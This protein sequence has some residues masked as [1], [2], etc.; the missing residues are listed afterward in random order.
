M[1]RDVC[2]MCNG[3]GEYSVHSGGPQGEEFVP[4]DQCDGKG[5][6]VAACDVPEPLVK[7]PTDPVSE[8]AEP[9]RE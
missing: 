7:E 5:Y 1:E 3:Y 2:P 9:V 8:P 6:T 4:C